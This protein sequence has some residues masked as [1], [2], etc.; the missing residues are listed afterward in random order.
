MTDRY[1][2]LHEYEDFIGAGEAGILCD[3]KYCPYMAG[4]TGRLGACDGDF[5]REAWDSFCESCDKEYER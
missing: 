5:C 4:T 3:D 2:S 1:M